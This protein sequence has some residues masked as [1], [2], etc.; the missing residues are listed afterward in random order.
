[1]TEQPVVEVYEVTD[2]QI[3]AVEAETRAVQESMTFEVV[4]A[5]TDDSH[6]GADESD[7]KAVSE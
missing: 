1:M 5:V 4:T 7:D 3:A 2:E 6:E